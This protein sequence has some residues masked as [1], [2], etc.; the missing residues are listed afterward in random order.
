MILQKKE[1]L[2]VFALILF[3]TGCKDRRTPPTLPKVD[4][5]KPT[6]EFSEPSKQAEYE[7]AWRRLFELFDPPATGE[8][9]VVTL[10]NGTRA[11]GVVKGYGAS[12]IVLV[13]GKTVMAIQREEIALDSLPD[14]YPEFFAR[15]EALSQVEEAVDA[16]LQKGPLP[17]IG[18][19]R[20]LLSDS[21]VPRAGPADRYP[22]A[23][24]ES[25][26][27]GTL[28][29]VKEQRGWWIRV[30]PVSAPGASFWVPLLATR[31]APNA[32]SEDDTETIAKLLEDGILTFYNPVE[33]EAQM[34]RAIWAG[35]E[36]GIR[37]GIARMLAA[38]S[39]ATREATVEWIE[40][41]ESES[42]RR[43]GRYSQAQGFRIY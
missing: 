6:I 31:P 28:L 5:P 7:S 42:G 38:H 20:V 3:L 22:R 26:G 41:K 35:T 36:P 11:G 14:L 30:E 15:R 18:S 40:I 10:R 13:D 16:R 2:P 12:E 39:A 27:R 1:L 32:P 29:E 8:H 25:P 9:L 4:P 23:S 37:E 33:S 19:K 34:P 43:L 21:T 17:L 24:S